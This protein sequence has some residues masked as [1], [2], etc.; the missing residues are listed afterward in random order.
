MRIRGLL[1]R[2][3]ALM[4]LA[5]WFGGFTFYSAAVLPVLHEVMGSLEA[6]S[7]TREVTDTLN[8][9]GASALSGW[10]VL[11]GAEWRLGRPGARRLRLGLLTADT[12]ILIGL[13]AL[14]PVMDRRLDTGSLRGFYP[15]HRVYLIA[16]TVQWV[17]N[18]ALV[19]VSLVVWQGTAGSPPARCESTHP[20]PDRRPP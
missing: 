17:V 3:L 16:S 11:A 9:A 8:L 20:A 7:V 14:H 10:W 12:A 15:L 1:L 2:W 6:G 5:V 18:L 13:F 19:A 4:A